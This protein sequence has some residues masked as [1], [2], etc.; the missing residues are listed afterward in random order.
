MLEKWYESPALVRLQA[1]HN[2]KRG[3]LHKSDFAYSIIKSLF[4]YS[5]SLGRNNSRD[6]DSNQAKRMRITCDTSVDF[7]KVTDARC[8][9]GGSSDDSDFLQIL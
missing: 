3:R 5:Q 4:L 9:G 6:H 7:N 2:T 8:P 1:F